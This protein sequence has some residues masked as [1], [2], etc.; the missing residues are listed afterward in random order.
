MVALF[1]PGT[2]SSWASRPPV[3]TKGVGESNNVRDTEGT[4]IP[5]NT[6]PLEFDE[7]VNV[8]EDP[9]VEGGANN[10]NS[11]SS[12]IVENVRSNEQV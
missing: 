10:V 1:I 6:G 4:A 12:A 5:R 8:V 2:S 7:R 9:A 11:P 3:A